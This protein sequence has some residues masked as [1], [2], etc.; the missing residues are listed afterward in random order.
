MSEVQQSMESPSDD[1]VGTESNPRSRTPENRGQETAA[2]ERARVAAERV[3]EKV[4]T[5]DG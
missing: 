4:E 1:E 3:L 5:G 2:R